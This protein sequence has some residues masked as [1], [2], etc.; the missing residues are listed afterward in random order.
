V[1]RYEHDELAQLLLVVEQLDLAATMLR[2]D[3]VA[4]VRAALILLDHHAEILLRRH[5]ESLFRAGDGKGPFVG[6]AY[7]KTERSKIR[8]NFASKLD[9]ASG[10]GKLG[11][12]VKPIIDGDFAACLRLAH[13]H[14]NAAYHRD[15]HNPGI[16][17]L[18][19]LLQ[20]QAVCGLL[21]AKTSRLVVGVP[22]D[23]PVL[24]RHG[25]KAGGVSGLRHAI[26]LRAAAEQVAKS[27]MGDLELPLAGVKAALA[28]DLLDRA[29]AA[30]G[31]ISEVLEAGLPSQNLYFAIEHDEFWETHG[32][33][34]QLV[35]LLQRSDP[36][37]RREEGDSPGRLPDEVEADMRLANNLRNQRYV[38]LRR[39]FRPKA[40]QASVEA[41][42]RQAEKLLNYRTLDEVLT[43]YDSADRDLAIF[44][45]HLPAAVQ[46]LGAME[47]RALDDALER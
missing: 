6:R 2:S 29:D 4:N 39:A 17:H 44:E 11:A 36:W 31:V 19:C 32:S 42:I 7:K 10:A 41:A 34:E 5:C 33:D 28:S 45:K 40:R 12:E 9:V 20:L 38:E 18:I 16:L 24:L 15:D 43:R 26:D 47:E 23:I 37:R 46:A 35:E 30:L 14:R 22:E 25:V 3:S 1:A 13:R 27:I 21:S 8:A